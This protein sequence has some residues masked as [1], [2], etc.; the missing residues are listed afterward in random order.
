MHNLYCTVHVY[1]VQCT[2]KSNVLQITSVCVICMHYIISTYLQ[3]NDD[4][5]VLKEGITVL[6][7]LLLL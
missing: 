4:W 3:D 1:P 7:V 5:K 2:V 6:H